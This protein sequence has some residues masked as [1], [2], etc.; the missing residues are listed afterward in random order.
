MQ[1]KPLSRT[2]PGR[3]KQVR[4]RA[5]ARLCAVVHALEHARAA[6]AAAAAA[7]VPAV[8]VS[9]PGAAA[10]LGVGYFWAL[11][12][13]A[14]GEFPGVAVEAV[15][16]CGDDPGFALAALRMGFKAVA[17]GGNRRARARVAAIARAMGA[18]LVARPRGALDLGHCPDAAQAC[19]RRLGRREPAAA[20]PV[21]KPRGPV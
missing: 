20:R 18:R 3:Q 1:V 7:G 14:R 2:R 9:P 5:K 13:A 21:A 10:Y 17:L 15:M 12:E 16:D 19:A 4:P 8:L 6:L 11:V